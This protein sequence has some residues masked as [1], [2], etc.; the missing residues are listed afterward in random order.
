MPNGKRMVALAIAVSE[1][2]PLPYLSGALNGA[3]DF[4][5]WATALGY[6]TRTLTDENKP[7]TIPRLRLELEAMLNPPA[8]PVHRL[9]LYFAGHGVIREAEEG[10]WLLS[11]WFNE[12]RA[13]AVEVLKR[14]LYAYNVNQIAIFADACR[15]L[16]A[17]IDVADLV[18][19]S[20]LGR[21]PVRP[22][23]PPPIDKFI[24]AQDGA[25]TYMVPGATPEEDRCIFSGIL[26]EGLWGAHP[27]AMSKILPGKVTSR[28][29]G[30]YLQA[31]V[32]EIAKRYHCTLAP[33]I[34]PNFPEGDDYYYGDGAT[35]TPPVFPEWPPPPA[36]PP[37]AQS[38]LKAP[39]S[40]GGGTRLGFIPPTI[41]ANSEVSASDTGPNQ[42]ML[43][44]LRNQSR[45]D[46]FETGA[47]FAV[48]GL[49]V[50]GVWTTSDVFAERDSGDAHGQWWRISEH[51]VG[52]ELRQPTPVL[53]EFA[54]GNF[55]ATVMMPKFIATI[56]YGRSGL[57]ALIYREIGTQRDVAAV[58]EEAIAE[59]ESGVLRANRAT[60][61][62]VELR[63]GK[64]SDPVRGVLSAYLYDSIGDIDNIQ[65]MAFYYIQEYQPIPYDI[66]MLAHIEG[67]WVDDCLWVHVPAVAKRDPRTAE[68]AKFPWT[69]SATQAAD[70]I[71]GGLW[72][73]MKQG[74]AFFV[75]LADNGSTLVL[76]GLAQLSV[77]VL[78]GRFSVLNALGG[79]ALIE[80]L[81][82]VP[83]GTSAT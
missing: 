3:R 9:I 40:L 34:F 46:H 21:G 58:T 77:H 36:E 65:R 4:G 54:D 12:L 51:F 43:A 5:K 10:L 64:H 26:L 71:V 48:Q 50:R 53:V 73:W 22:P 8:A 37:V 44:Q 27:E 41:P 17:N 49:P 57:S 25:K 31:E 19:D 18:A 55:A 68:E 28:S 2:K 67:K 81:Q 33:S 29:L 62:A 72:P 80:R 78:R 83:R 59:M 82:L 14:R 7:V 23:F 1:A 66:A 70:G 24:A 76:P 13:V 16:P 38:P 52:G 35:P 74:W 6:E 79:R 75:D 30:A 39:S 11:D 47:G 45:P 20:V 60:D 42:Q 69:Y 63:Q 61:L 15:S 56:L 32:P